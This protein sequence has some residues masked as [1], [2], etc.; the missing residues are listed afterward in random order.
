MGT[1]PSKIWIPRGNFQLNVGLSTNG[2]TAFKG[3]VLKFYPN[4]TTTIYQFALFL[5]T[6][7]N[8]KAS[9]VEYGTTQIDIISQQEFDFVVESV[10]GNT[11]YVLSICNDVLKFTPN[12]GPNTVIT[13][14]KPGLQSME[15]LELGFVEVNLDNNDSLTWGTLVACVDCTYI[16]PKTVTKTSFQDT[17]VIATI[18]VLASVAA[19][20]ISLFIAS[21]VKPAAF[22][23]GAS[24]VSKRKQIKS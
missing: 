24:N 2:G 12:A 19:V 15:I 8:T 6:T 17:S 4:A 14:T 7:G 18:A 23:K 20:F 5:G 16:P 21:I 9:L 22:A 10:S 3:A 11:S 13:A 1:Q